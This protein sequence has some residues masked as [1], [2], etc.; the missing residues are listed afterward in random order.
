[1]RRMLRSKLTP[2]EP[3][4][5]SKRRLRKG[6]AISALHPKSPT[7]VLTVQ[8]VSQSRLAPEEE[9]PEN[10]PPLPDPSLVTWPSYWM[11]PTL[12]PNMNAFCRSP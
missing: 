3:A 5:E 7:R 8:E 2:Q 12:V 6:I 11:P 1:M 10:E 9:P 4:P